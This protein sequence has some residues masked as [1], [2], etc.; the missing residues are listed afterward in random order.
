[1]FHVAGHDVPRGD[2]DAFEAAMRRFF[3]LPDSEKRALRRSR[4]NAWG[5]FDQELTKNRPDWK[6]VF[7][8]GDERRADDPDGAHSDG[9]NQ[10]SPVT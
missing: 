3:D 8:Y 9:V 4:D 2:L 1:M 5:Y 10:C 6:E 7:D